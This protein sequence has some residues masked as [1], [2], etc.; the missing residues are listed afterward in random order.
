MMLGVSHGTVK[1]AIATCG[2][3][4]G[5]EPAQL[6]GGPEVGA[7]EGQRAARDAHGLALRGARD[8]EQQAGVV[9][10][11]VGRGAAQLRLF[12]GVVKASCG[13]VGMLQE[14]HDVLQQDASTTCGGRSWPMPGMA[15]KRAPGMRRAVS[16]PQAIGT[17]GSAS[18][19]STSVGDL[20]RGSIVGAARCRRR[21]P[22]SAAPR[23]PGGRRGACRARTRSRQRLRRPADR[24]GCAISLQQPHAV[25]RPAR[26]RS[27]LGGPAQQRAQRRRGRGPG[28]P[29]A[30]LELMMLVEAE[31]ARCGAASATRCAIMPPIEAPTTWARCDAQR[32]EH[33]ER[34]VGHVLQRVGRAHAQADA[35]AHAL[36]QQVAARRARSKPW[37]RPMSRLSKRTTRIA[38]IDQRLRRSR[39]A[40]DQLH[41]Q[42]HDEQ[43]HR[44]AAC[45]VAAVLDLDLDPVGLDLHGA[46]FTRI[47]R[48][49]SHLVAIHFSP[50]S[51]GAPPCSVRVDGCGPVVAEEDAGAALG[52][53]FEADVGE[54]GAA[55][56]LRLLQVHHQR[57]HALAAALAGWS[58]CRARPGSK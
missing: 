12:R 41:A 10:V 46:G 37:H 15:T 2:L 11:D 33:A 48:S 5:V 40:S 22:A 18:P 24:P 21:W 47:R 58:A 31:H 51:T 8:R 30:P 14:G 43:H 26:P 49:R 25:R 27:R 23:R 7:E 16:S 57:G 54:G 42:A 44:P 45:A 13:V 3:P 50:A 35:L 9:L 55:A 56:L 39:A 38:G 36:P 53:D 17:S 52:R 29:R 19:C 6:E 28:R 32:V 1:C 20:M 4:R 34:V